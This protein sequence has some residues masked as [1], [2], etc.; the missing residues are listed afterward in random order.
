MKR[1]LYLICGACW[2]SG[3]W[4]CDSHMLGE[5]GYKCTGFRFILKNK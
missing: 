1:K 3:G 4:F 5:T 2:D